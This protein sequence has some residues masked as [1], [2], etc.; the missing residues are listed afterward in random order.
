M[1]SQCKSCLERITCI[2]AAIGYKEGRNALSIRFLDS[3]VCGDRRELGP[4]GYRGTD[5]GY[6]RDTAGASHRLNRH[7]E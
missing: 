4:R 2:Y 7:S 1:L 3:L 6:L 5:G